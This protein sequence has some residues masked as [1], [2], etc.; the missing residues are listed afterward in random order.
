MLCWLGFSL[1]WLFLLCF[2]WSSFLFLGKGQ[3]F[4]LLLLTL[5]LHHAQAVLLLEQVEVLIRR[6]VLANDRIIV[7]DL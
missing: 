5:I 4:N 2:G 3:L 1:L 7:R 6:P